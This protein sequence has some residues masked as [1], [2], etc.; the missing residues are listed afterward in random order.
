MTTA[1]PAWW[2]SAPGHPHLLLAL[3]SWI[4]QSG[5]EIGLGPGL[6]AGELQIPLS[7]VTDPTR[8][9]IATVVTLVATGVRLYSTWYLETDDHYGSSPPPSRS[10]PRRCS[11]SSSPPTSS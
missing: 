5:S 4:S 2:P 3:V 7:V 9:A 8:L 11:S 10:S 1:S 6:D